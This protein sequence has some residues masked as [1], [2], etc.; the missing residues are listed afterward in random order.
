M[1]RHHMRFF[2]KCAAALAAGV[3]LGLFVT[4]LTIVRGTPMGGDVRD[5]AWRTSLATGSAQGGAWL[6]ANV[7]L[8]GLLALGRTEAIY[9]NATSD[10]AGDA[11]DGHCTYRIAGR[12]PP[13]RWW[14]ITAYGADDYLI[15]SASS[16][17]AVSK[18]SVV[19]HID[20]SFSVGV[21]RDAG[22]VD[23][24]ASGDG[25]FTLTLR[26][27]NPGAAVAADP[28]HVALPTIQK[29]RCT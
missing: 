21:L 15:P 2:G 4:W 10:S 1:I 19:H 29:V 26:L 13:A 7:A 17:F 20:G 11:L 28:A 22:A 5:G 23:E 25:P 24:I 3:V 12:D 9:Y 14:S 18:N 27:Y 8:H 6:R 16:L